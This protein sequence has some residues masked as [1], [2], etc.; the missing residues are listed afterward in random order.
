[1]LSLDVV[2][3]Y[4]LSWRDTSAQLS[5]VKEGRLNSAGEHLYFAV[6]LGKQNI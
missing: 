3:F 5:R 2:S 1:M 6:Q 4:M